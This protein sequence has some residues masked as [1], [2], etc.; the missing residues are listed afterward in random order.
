M[1]WSRRKPWTLVFGNA[2]K[3]A[4]R[5]AAVIEPSTVAASGPSESSGGDDS[6]VAV[7]THHTGFPIGQFVG[8]LL[9]GAVL[10]VGTW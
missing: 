5:S 6:A 8:P 2:A 3:R 1:R 10:L 7:G 4:A 9:I